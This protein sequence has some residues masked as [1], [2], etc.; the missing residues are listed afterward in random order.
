MKYFKYYIFPLFSLCLLLSACDETLHIN[1]NDILNSV[2]APE[3]TD[4]VPQSGSAGAEI[5]LSGLGFA[6]ADSVQINGVRTRI[7]NKISDT[8]MI[9]EIT[10]FETSGKIKVFNNKGT[11]QSAG[12]FTVEY[13]EPEDVT[14]ELN[15]GDVLVSDMPLDITGEGLKSVT[16]AFLS[17]TTDRKAQIL[18]QS[19]NLLTILIPVICDSE[20]DI[21]LEY[22]KGAEAYYW[23]SQAYPTNKIIVPPVV[24][25]TP[26][27]AYKG[28]VITVGVTN[29]DRIDNIYFG[30]DELNFV[31]SSSNQIKITLPSYFTQDMT[32]DLWMTHNACEDLTI[33]SGFVVVV[34]NC[35]SYFNLFTMAQGGNG[36]STGAN[37]TASFFDG[38]HGTYTNCEATSHPKDI[39]FITYSN[40]SG[41]YV[42]YGP[43]AL[44]EGTLKNFYCGTNALTAAGQMNVSEFNSVTVKFRRLDAANATQKELID[45]FN[46]CEI[47]DITD[48]LFTGITAP[49]ANNISYFKNTSGNSTYTPGDV[50]WFQNSYTNKNG[51]MRVNVVDYNGTAQDKVANAFIDVLYQK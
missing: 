16:A 26:A 19:D 25:S 50:I 41:A 48:D 23:V 45:K 49:S 2:K 30:T 14:V 33:Q 44:A 15:P 5:T 8:Q 18:F 31:I 6:T 22:H 17:G 28:Q 24:L 11:G 46:N 1:E 35:Y 21:K 12:N 3:V 51:L 7:K 29:P 39:E 20:A 43:H 40:G 42:F 34:P 10:G 36:G 4:F 13:V 47:K 32:A 9:I 38:E 37:S 27:Q